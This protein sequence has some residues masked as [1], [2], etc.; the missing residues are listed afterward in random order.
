MSVHD[1]LSVNKGQVLFWSAQLTRQKDQWT[2]K[3]KSKISIYA[4]TI[5]ASWL[6]GAGD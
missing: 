2:G 1:A 3:A 5:W 6:W 4:E